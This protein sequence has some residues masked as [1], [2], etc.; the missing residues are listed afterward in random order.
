MLENTVECFSFSEIYQ[1]R[2]V[3]GPGLVLLR[4][5]YSQGNRQP[6]FTHDPVLRDLEIPT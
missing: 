3:M 2:Q 6:F 1:Y 4:S 5:L